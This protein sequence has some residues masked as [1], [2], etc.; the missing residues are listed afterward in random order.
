M[1][2]YSYSGTLEI[3]GGRTNKYGRSMGFNQMG[4][5]WVGCQVEK[6]WFSNHAKVVRLENAGKPMANME[7]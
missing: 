3:S 5:A 1:K 4:S 7:I 6:C 2:T